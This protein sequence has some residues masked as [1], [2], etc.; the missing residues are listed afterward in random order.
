MKGVFMNFV[1]KAKAALVALPLVA[2]G[3]AHAALDSS[4]TTAIGAAKADITEAGGLVLGV[5]LAIAAF[6]WIKRMFR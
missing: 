1:Q 4:V 2:A 3:A 6:V 5:A